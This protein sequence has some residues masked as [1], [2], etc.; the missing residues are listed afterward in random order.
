MQPIKKIVVIGATGMLGR[1]VTQ[2]LIHAGF[3]VTILARNIDKAK[4]HF[5]EAS[6]IKGDLQD[7]ISLLKAFTS[8]DGVYCNLNIPQSTKPHEWLSEREGIDNIVEAA[9]QAKIRCIGLISSV[10]MNYQGMNGF[11]WWVFDVKKEAVKEINQSGI[12]TL[13]FYPSTFMD[14]FLYTYKR[15]KRILLAGTSAVPMH[16]IAGEDFGKQVAR[17]YQLMYGE[18]KEYVIQGP[19]AYT[20][21]QAAKIFVDNYS[22][23]K[24]SA[25]KV[26]LG[27]LKFLGKFSRQINYGSHIIEALNNYPEKF[28]SQSTWRELGD[29]S[30]TLKA[31]AQKHSQL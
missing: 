12:P 28:V 16:Y 24:L 18:S 31:F 29:P 25:S 14:N 19:E 9:R 10:V 7:T 11:Q 17:A 30:L 2:A 6:I 5:P 15:G 4:T 3:A 13:I 22:R 23:E 27:L 8:Q 1:P 26:P 21:D 20:A